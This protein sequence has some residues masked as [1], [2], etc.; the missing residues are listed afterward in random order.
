[1][2]Y[3]GQKRLFIFREHHETEL[4]VCQLMNI[5]FYFNH[6]DIGFMRSG[7]FR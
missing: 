1:M 5:E 3:H 7:Y 4:P 6:G 2:P